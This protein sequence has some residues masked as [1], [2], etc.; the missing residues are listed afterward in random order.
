MLFKWANATWA[1]WVAIKKYT[2][3]VTKLV[4]NLEVNIISNVTVVSPL[5]SLMN[6]SV[7]FVSILI[8][9]T[10]KGTN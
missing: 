2:L 9:I 1:I 10:E 5:E 8:I 4:K 3:P 7:T 6:I